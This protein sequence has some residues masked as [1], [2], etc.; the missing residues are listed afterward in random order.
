MDEMVPGS[1]RKAFV[2]HFVADWVFA[3]PLLVAPAWFLRQFGWQHVDPVACRII[4]AALFGIGTE[5]LLGRNAKRE[6]YLTM[7]RLKIIWSSTACLGFV[8]SLAQGAPWG[9]WLFLAIFASFFV[10]WMRFYLLIRQ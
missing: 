7:L 2:F 4:A 3:V 9:T 8:V 1:L 5:S 10:I 6:S